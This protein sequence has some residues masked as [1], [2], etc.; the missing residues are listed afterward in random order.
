MSQINE[1]V[2]KSSKFVKTPSFPK[3][4]YDLTESDVSRVARNLGVIFDMFDE[5]MD[6]KDHVKSVVH[7]A[8]FAIYRI[9]QLRRY[10]DKPSVERL[11]HAFVSS[12]PV[13]Q[14]VVY[15]IALLTFKA[16]H[17]LAPTYIIELISPGG[18]WDRFHKLSLVYVYQK[19]VRPN[20]TVKGLL[21]QQHLKCGTSYPLSLVLYPT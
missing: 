20:S 19:C 11:I 5:S 21:L 1:V 7:A 14:R 15:K 17:R 18:P 6:V 2:H 10:L 4:T 3:I 9:G 12:L 13:Q 16:L 8:T